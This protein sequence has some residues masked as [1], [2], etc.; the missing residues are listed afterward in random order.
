M[1]CFSDSSVW[2]CVESMPERESIFVDSELKAGLD[3]LSRI[4]SAVNTERKSNSA[5]FIPFLVRVENM[6]AGEQQHYKARERKT[7]KQTTLKSNV[8]S[9]AVL[10]DDNAFDIFN[11]G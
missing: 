9:T 11:K 4:E 6:L 7:R 2:E 8:D 5:K 10:N 1:G 3:C